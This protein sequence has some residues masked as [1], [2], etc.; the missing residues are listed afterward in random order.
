M[1]PRR[2]ARCFN[3]HKSGRAYTRCTLA[4]EGNPCGI[5]RSIGTD[6]FIARSSGSLRVEYTAM[7]FAEP[8]V[9]CARTLIKTRWREMKIQSKDRR[10]LYVA[11]V[12][13]YLYPA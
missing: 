10:V 11:P 1:D 12:L 2:D 8:K 6:L 4:Q 9:T 5:F 7:Q 13:R 3:L